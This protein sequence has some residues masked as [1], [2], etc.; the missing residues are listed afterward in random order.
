MS[1]CP[2]PPQTLSCISIFALQK[3][4][5]P[6]LSP[7]YATDK[8]IEIGTILISWSTIESLHSSSH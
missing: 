3:Q 7:G 8:G 2:R 4:G 1:P 6:K 5:L